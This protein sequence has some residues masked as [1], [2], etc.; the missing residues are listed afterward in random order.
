MCVARHFAI[1]ADVRAAGLPGL[2]RGLRD[3]GIQVH[4]DTLDTI[5]AWAADAP[6]P[7]RGAAVHHRCALALEDDRQQKV[8]Q[9]QALERDFATHLCRT[10]YVL[11]LSCP[12]IN[13]VSAAD[14]A[15]EMGPVEHYASARTIT[16]RAGLCPSRYQSDQVD[17]PHG[18]LV[19][20][21]NRRLRGAI[22]RVA[23]NFIK[24]NTGLLPKIWS[25]E[26]GSR[27][28]QTQGEGR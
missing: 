19:P 16:G 8:R 28:D 1:P 22:L 4:G 6:P 13:V 20:C 18:P 14:F 5:L 21:G 10:P 2:R 3:A 9:V 12:G 25:S 15:A 23:D 7:D 26:Y 17:N 11:L 27:R 24:C